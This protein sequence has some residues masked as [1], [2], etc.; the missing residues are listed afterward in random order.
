MNSINHNGNNLVFGKWGGIM[1]Q[2]RLVN[3]IQCYVFD[4]L[5]AADPGF[6]RE[7]LRD[8]CGC[9]EQELEELGM[10]FLTIQ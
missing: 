6:V 3:I 10:G 7:K 4:D 2:Q 5:C 8:V 9:T 1:E